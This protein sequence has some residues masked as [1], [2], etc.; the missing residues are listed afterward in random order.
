MSTGA[1]C[2][3]CGASLFPIEIAEGQ[4]T[5]CLR[6][7]PADLASDAV[8][9][10]LPEPR[11]DGDAARARE[12][13][14][15]DHDPYHARM[16]AAEGWGGMRVGVA[17]IYWG[18]L[19]NLVTLGLQILMIPALCGGV[20]PLVYLLTFLSAGVT[21]ASGVLC[22]VGLACMLATISAAVLLAIF[23]ISTP[24]SRRSLVVP[25]AL[26]F[27]WF[28]G[29]VVLVFMTT[30]AYTLVMRAAARYW[31][32]RELAN[33]FMSF[34]CVAWVGFVILVIF[35]VCL[36]SS[37][38]SSFSYSRELLVVLNCGFLIVGLFMTV[39]FLSLLSRLREAIPSGRP[40][41]PEP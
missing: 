26:V 32:D 40:W 9:A 27:L 8:T 38:R 5:R 22:L 18:I 16:A 28:V 10:D 33:S 1:V 2:P 23:A 12:Y 30:L 36:G 31:G 6:R 21:L 37:V 24:F 3:G 15:R 11:R 17:L 34:F 19:L 41:V 29:I 39:W 20:R 14:S 7:L 4:C 35:G 25:D 13:D